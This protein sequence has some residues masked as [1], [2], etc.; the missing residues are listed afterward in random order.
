[1]ADDQVEGVIGS[2]SGPTALPGAGNDHGAAS[3]F[4]SIASD[5]FIAS[6]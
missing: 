6:A 1:M 5:S 4:R 3:A 2:A